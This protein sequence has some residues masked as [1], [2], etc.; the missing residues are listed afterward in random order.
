MIVDA[1]SHVVMPE[2][3][4]RFMAGLVASRANP[5]EDPKLPSDEI[6]RPVTERHIQNMD[7]VGTDVQFI[8]PRPCAQLRSLN[9][10]KVTQT[11]TRYVNDLIH[12]QCQLFPERLRG[13]AGLPPH[14]D[15]S[16]TSCPAEPQRPPKERRV[17]GG[18]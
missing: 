9:P 2:A 3:P 5:I 14:R 6:L 15:S 18:P 17:G 10:S 1:H 16:P 13:G 8:S 12:R 11:W 7:K 4:G